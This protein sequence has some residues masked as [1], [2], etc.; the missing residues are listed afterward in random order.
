MLADV[1][2]KA[3]F[4]QRWAGTPLNERQTLVLNRVIDGMEGK[5]TNAKWASIA[6]CSP[7][8]TLRDINGL[9]TLG[10]LGK[11]RCWACQRGLQGV[12]E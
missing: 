4:W 1:L 2:D 11:L 7:D 12:F 3:P 10:V 5:L 8:T 9:L 6:E